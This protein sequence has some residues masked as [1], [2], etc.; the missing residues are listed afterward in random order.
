MLGVSEQQ[1]RAWE[2]Q[3]WIRSGEPISGQILFDFDSAEAGGVRSFPAEPPPDPAVRERQAEFWFQ[4]GL[5]LEESEAP[6]KEAIEA[7]RRAVDLN[8]HAAGA[9][10]NLGTIHY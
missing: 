7:Y 1:L 8:P 5:A 6:V 9:W 4:R 10:V 2:R 3:G